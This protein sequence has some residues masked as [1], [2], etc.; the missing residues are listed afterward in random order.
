MKRRLALVLALAL[1]PGAARADAHGQGIELLWAGYGELTFAWLNHGPD[2]S[3]AHGAQAD[4]RLVF[5]QTRFSLELEGEL[6]ADF[7]FE[8]EIEFEHGGTGSAVELEYDEFGEFEQEVEKGGEVVLEELYLQKSF[9][10]RLRVRVGRFYVA[11]GQ[12][13]ENFRPTQYLAAARSEAET[14]MLPA[15]WD[16]MGVDATLSLGDFKITGQV[17]NGLDSTG[18]STARFISPGHQQRF[19]LMRASDLAGVLRVDWL[20]MAGMRFGTAAYRGGT[21]RNRPKPDLAKDCPNADPDVVADCGYVG[22]PLTLLDLHAEVSLAG[23]RGQGAVIWGQLAEAA[24]ISD[25]NARLSNLLGVS[26]TPVSDEALAAW[27]E[28]GYDVGRLLGTEH[29]RLEPFV[30]FDHVDTVFRPR[31]A[32]YDDP[33]FARTVYTGGLAWTGH[34]LIVA[35]LDFSHRRLGADRFRPENAARL[36]TGFIF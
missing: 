5:D 6:P 22:A 27:A 2:Q 30:R 19:E 13:S 1:Q 36:S 35:K 8:A 7:E 33:R 15:V 18:F 9:G 31:K 14:T 26:R 34:D 28:V 21:T 20:P 29:H 17:V 24:R 16:E 23:W 12:L 10:E 32:M 11:L 4:S 3:R 25:R